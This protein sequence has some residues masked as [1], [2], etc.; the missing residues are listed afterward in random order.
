MRSHSWRLWLQLAFSGMLNQQQ[1][2]STEAVLAKLATIT[3]VNTYG[4][5]F[6]HFNLQSE[7]YQQTLDRFCES[8]FTRFAADV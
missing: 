3:P 7:I 1:M 6:K 8:I 5:Q 2:S 4:D